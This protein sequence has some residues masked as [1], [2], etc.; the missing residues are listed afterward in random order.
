[1]T[2]TNIPT[3]LVPD[4]GL[5]NRDG[6]K[7]A[8]GAIWKNGVQVDLSSLPAADAA[9]VTHIQQDNPT[10]TADAPSDPVVGTPN[11]T[12]STPVTASTLASPA[13]PTDKDYAAEVRSN[14]QYL[15]EKLARHQSQLPADQYNEMVAALDAM[16]QQA[17]NVA[18]Q[19]A[20]SPVQMVAIRI[21]M[22]KMVRPQL[23]E[24]R[25]QL[26]AMDKLPSHRSTDSAADQ[27]KYAKLNA[28]IDKKAAQLGEGLHKGILAIGSTIATGWKVT[29]DAVGGA[30]DDV[31]KKGPVKAAGDVV[32]DADQGIGGF[33]SRFTSHMNGGSWLGGLLGMAGAWLVGT[34]F[35]G[36]IIGIIITLLLVPMGF[37]M[38][39]TMGRDHLNGLFGGKNGP[40]SAPATGA[41]NGQAP[42]GPVTQQTIA[43]N[44]LASE[45]S[46]GA[47]AL[48][49]GVDA[50]MV[51][52]SGDTRR[53]YNAGTA[54]SA[55]RAAAPVI[56]YNMQ[57]ASGYDTMP[58]SGLPASAYSGVVRGS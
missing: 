49:P 25:T 12:T 19:P 27:A 6:Y 52:S 15:K 7:I 51:A 36:G 8:N 17:Q 28:D 21:M 48:P 11:V 35:P 18:A 29:A 55:Q 54:Y 31:T 33:L 16:D 34:M 50:D 42:A 57:Q 13:N 39:S 47:A 22:E 14:T 46:Y 32:H 56:G 43:R 9:A 53:V 40:S 20:P 1:M 5:L 10:A 41:G 45:T 3:W 58:S 26:D 24:M 38:G 37:M 2:D 44:V 4:Y 23:Q 30:V